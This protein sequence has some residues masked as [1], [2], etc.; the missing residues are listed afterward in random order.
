MENLFQKYL[1][2][3]FRNPELLKPRSFAPVVTLSREYGCPS[4]LIGQMLVKSI[5]S[6]LTQSHSTPW[7]MINKEI[8]EE[9]ARELNIPEVQVA[10]M[11]SAEEKGVVMDILTFSST[12]G[13]SHRVRKTVEKVLKNFAARGHIV[14]VGRGG[15]AVLR[16]I[17]NSLHIKLHAPLEWRANEISEKKGISAK[18]ALE[19]IREVDF[20]RNKLLETLLGKTIDPTLFDAAFNCKYLSKEEI[21]MSIV[22]LLE[23]RK[24]I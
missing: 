21:V 19:C 3:S 24:M 13:G 2:E 1:E 23:L 12:Y 11:L 20:K 15:V 9:A 5:N 14:L 22:K 10:S 18:E 7:Q 16:E 6:R 17:P 4:K 8:I